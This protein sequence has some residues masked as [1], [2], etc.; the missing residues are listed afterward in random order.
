M[1]LEEM[2]YLE[3]LNDKGLKNLEMTE[4]SR[5]VSILVRMR[6]AFYGLEIPKKFDRLESLIAKQEF[7]INKSKKKEDQTLDVKVQNQELVCDKLD[8]F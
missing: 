2:A 3:D 5:Q 4:L 8:K 6:I 7:V 1:T